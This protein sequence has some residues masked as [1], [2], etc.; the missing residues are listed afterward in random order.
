[1]IGADSQF[2]SFHQSYWGP[3][4]VTCEV[5]GPQAMQIDAR[6]GPATKPYTTNTLM[7][8]EIKPTELLTGV[9]PQGGQMVTECENYSAKGVGKGKCK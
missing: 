3:K 2:D 4:G 9:Q 1:M 5:T 7:P 8:A 6:T